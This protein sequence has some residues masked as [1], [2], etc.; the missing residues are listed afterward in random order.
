MRMRHDPAY[1]ASTDDA[2]TPSRVHDQFC[3]CRAC[4][5]PLEPI[6][7]AA[8]DLLLLKA[9][10]IVGSIGLAVLIVLSAKGY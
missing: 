5:P 10:I 2:G 9:I 4:K 6:G 1:L 7:T 3:R 8:R